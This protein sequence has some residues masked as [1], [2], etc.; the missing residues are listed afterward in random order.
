MAE[1]VLEL[2]GAS[3]DATVGTG[4]TLVDFW[5]PWC[6]PCRM[7]G[8]ILEQVGRALAGRARVAK[9]NVDDNRDLAAKFGIRSIPALLL[10]KDGKV[11]KQFVGLTRADPLQA[12]I[13]E[14][15]K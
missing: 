15:L 12:A 7:Q 3:F 1:S 2:T 10:F 13:E 9:V 11:A 8:P 4:V 6:G 14:A 5:A